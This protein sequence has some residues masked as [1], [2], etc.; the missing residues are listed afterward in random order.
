MLSYAGVPEMSGA[1]RWLEAAASPGSSVA[2]PAAASPPAANAP[3]MRVA[4]PVRPDPL[5]EIAVMPSVLS[6]NFSDGQG[7]A[8]GGPFGLVGNQKL[9]LSRAPAFRPS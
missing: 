5:L 8:A 9:F 4:T 3:H 6:A 1:S 7:Y 2:T